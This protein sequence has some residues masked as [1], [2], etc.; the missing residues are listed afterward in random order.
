MM[1]ATSPIA[2]PL[3]FVSRRRMRIFQIIV[4]VVS[5]M[6]S[7]AGLE[8]GLR[9]LEKWRLGD[10]AELTFVP[11]SELGNR[12]AGNTAKSDSGGFR[13]D[14]VPSH[15]EIVAIGDSQTWGINAD[16]H[17]AWPQQLE[18][19]SGH[20]VYNMS[21][22][23]YGTLHY[24]VLAQRTQK[25]SPRIIVVGLYFGN[26]LYDT[27][28]LAYT[29]PNYN[30]LR[31]PNA[32]ADLETDT[33]GPRADLYWNHEKNFHNSFGRTSLAGMSYWTRE[34]LAIGR[35][36]NKVGLWPGA[37]DVDYEIDR[38][39]AI[40]NPDYG[41]VYEQGN[42]STVF[43]PA[44]RLEGLDLDEPR[45]SEGLR[46]SKLLL[47]YIRKAAE[48]NN[49]RMMVVMIPTKEAVYANALKDRM[50]VGTTFGRML[51]MESRA[52][53]ELMS[54]CTEQHV[55]CLDVLPFMS[56]AISRD[57]KIYSSTTESHPIATGY[58]IIAETVN[59]A[60]SRLGW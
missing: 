29:N 52:R 27:Y 49:S 20:S 28:R 32:S 10:S 8:I 21:L 39:W 59:Q 31:S 14:D 37:T 38:A 57:E 50:A 11:D 58:A 26:D 60:I 15:A 19:L 30:E 13:N 43:T 16:R 33:V 56:A 9:L 3:N 24:W 12:L 46:I 40:A 23:G 5:L 35:L 51:S 53:S 34:H 48:A 18:K 45:V 7:L 25:F 4:L 17:Y 54:A 22:G 6:V 36:L 42:V 47:G 55:E 1:E 2:A 41:A 44:Y